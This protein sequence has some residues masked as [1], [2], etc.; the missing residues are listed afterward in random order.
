MQLVAKNHIPSRL[1]FILREQNKLSS[2]ATDNYKQLVQSAP[3]V[4]IMIVPGFVQE[5]QKSIEQMSE[6][7]LKVQKK[8]SVINQQ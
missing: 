7:G 4:L 3:A 6:E 1:I 5:P 2:S 8:Q